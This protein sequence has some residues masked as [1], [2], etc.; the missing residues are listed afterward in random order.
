[1]K[2]EILKPKDSKMKEKHEKTILGISSATNTMG[3]AVY[4]GKLM[5]ECSI[6]GDRARSEQI[7]PLINEVLQRSGLKIKD[8]DA[9]AVTKGP[10]SY[11]GLRGGIA[12]AKGLVAAL[13]IPI[14]SVPTLDSAAYNFID[15]EGT[16]LV[17]L[18]A[19]KDE[20]NISLFGAHKGVVKRLTKDIV[21]TI[22]GISKVI[23]KV[24]GELTISCDREIAGIIKNKNIRIASRTSAVPWAR[25]TAVIGSEKFKK[26]EF[27]DALTL[28]PEYSHKPNI[29][30]WKK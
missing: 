8:I 22:D 18:H 11:S 28:V 9:V 12:V 26:H 14:I 13:D 1:M 20:Y 23:N 24:E 21:T 10:G 2:K 3:A 27:V 17:A 5:A 19:C 25:N 29:R 7:V 15:F 6:S 4:N 16:F 30:E